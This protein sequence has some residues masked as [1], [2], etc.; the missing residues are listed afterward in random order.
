MNLRPYQTDAIE[1]VE[2]LLA[3][4]RRRVLLV[5]P[6][7]CHE[8][9]TRVLMHDG[10]VRAVED[11]RVGDWLM[12]PD[13][14][15]REV[16]QLARGRDQM[17]RIV[18]NKGESFV[19]N[20]DHVLSLVRSN[21]GS[22]HAGRIVDV[23]VREWL[24]WSRT[25][26]HVHKLFRVAVDFPARDDV[27]VLDPYFLGLFLGDGTTR[28]SIGISKPDAEVRAEAERVA[29]GMGMQVRADGAGTT[30]VTWRF[31]TGRRGVLNPMRAALASLGLA[32]SRSGDKFIPDR[33][34]RGSRRERLDLLAG[35]IDSDGH[36]DHGGCDY[37]TQS[38]R[39]ADDILFLAR[40]LGFAAYGHPCEKRDQNGNGG[41]YHR[42]YI[43]GDLS[44]VPTR[45][46]RK[47]APA[48]RQIKSVLRTGFTVEPLD[49][50]D[51]YGFMLDGDHR[52]VMG[53]FTVTHNSGKTVIAAE[54]IRRL[55]LDGKRALFLAAQKELVEQT[56][57]KLDAAGV[58]HGIIMAGERG[59]A[60]DVQVASV[61]TL[62]R[63]DQM[64]A[65]DVIFI[66]EADLA[67][68]ESY[69]KILA[70]YPHA[71]VIGM[72]G[73]P[74]RADGKGLGELFRDLVVVATPRELI[75]AGYLVDF[76]GA[77]FDA[78]DTAGIK[79]TAGDYDKKELGDRATSTD[80]GRKLVGDIVREY[81]SRA[82]G[83]RAACF[84]V[85]IAHSKMLAQQFLD[86]GV[87]AE[88]IDG[89]MPKDQRAA[90]FDRVR[91]GETRVLCNYGIV[92]RGVDVPALE[93]AILARPTKSLS[94]YL[95]MAGRVLRPSPG[96][97]RAMLFDHAGLTAMHGFPDDV[98]DY[99]LDFDGKKKACLVPSIGIQR[100]RACFIVVESG[101]DSCPHCGV[102]FLRERPASSLEHVPGTAVDFDAIRAAAR[103]PSTEVVELRD[104]LWNAAARGKAA[105]VASFV[106]KQRHGDWPPKALMDAA[107]RM[108]GLQVAA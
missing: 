15:P 41:T 27:P 54:F 63:R 32:D 64:P 76:G 7:G 69:D 1:R 92:T 18:P 60:A 37:I 102:S 21:D 67:R 50:D 17:F 52:Y 48:R 95:Q 35:L 107:K 57:A 90:I 31:T 23:T 33:F 25:M 51:F 88:H 47:V 82:P 81:L 45:I 42:V 84:A 100:C 104:L 34:K 5:A 91:S 73:T 20:G 44:V 85:N 97:D 39:L 96:K 68:A 24:G 8:R 80:Q 59:T 86:A 49:V 6:T 75:D 29:A 62:V 26:K 83:K 72:T 13:S 108:A 58:R 71:A 101:L 11:V 28:G 70:H 55:E 79:T 38:V 89:A 36:V 66:D 30:S 4:G 103:A 9:G 22:G 56:S 14:T 99:S 105:N 74:W 3:A 77:R 12:G 43:S 78:L 106:W 2:R 10:S 65:A 40:S 19:V 61:Q 53:D 87:P 94:L 98:R 93:V 46:P 16:L